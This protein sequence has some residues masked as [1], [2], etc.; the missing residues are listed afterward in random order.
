MS[1]SAILKW[2]KLNKIRIATM[3][4]ALF[5]L[6]STA[7]TFEALT[8]GNEYDFETRYLNAYYNTGTWET[9]DG[10]THNE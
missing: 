6:T 10:H 4:L 8:E 9:A 7:Q 1:I 2:L 3:L 5:M